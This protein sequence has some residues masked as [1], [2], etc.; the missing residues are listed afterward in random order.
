VTSG[1]RSDWRWVPLAFLVT[2]LLAAWDTR[3]DYSKAEDGARERISALTRVVEARTNQT[4]QNVD[5]MLRDAGDQLP[6]GAN[7]GDAAFHR[8]LEAR[9]HI[10]AEALTITIVSPEGIIVN[11]SSAQLVGRNVGNRSYLGHFRAHPEDDSLF[12]GE[13]V[14]A[15]LNR[16]VVFAA[17]AIRD[18][19]GG[20]RAIAVSALLPEAFSSLLDA[21]V[22]SEPSGA[23]SL[24]NRDQIILARYPDEG[25]LAV[26]QSLAKAP[27][28]IAHLAG[29]GTPSY[30]EGVGGIDGVRRLIGVRTIQPYGITVGVSIAK[31]DVMNPVY[32]G[33]AGNL[34]L[35][36]AV[37]GGAFL[38][39]RNAR[40]RDR[41]RAEAER[42]LVRARDH[43][44]KILDDF[45]A[46]IRLTDDL[47]QCEYVNH[48]WA[49]FTGA[50]AMAE[51]GQG[52]IA[53]VHPEDMERVTGR[54]ATQD[55]WEYRLRRH[56]GE[57]R[58]LHE[59]CRPF[60]NLDGRR[61]GTLSACLDVTE[62]RR[63]QQQ[64]QRS[65]ADL[66]QFA[67]VASHDL[68]EPLRMVSNFMALLERRYGSQLGDE[69]REFLAF[70]KDGAVRMDRLVLDLLDFSRVG[71]ISDPPRPN[72]VG[73]LV[74]RAVHMLQAVI[75]QSGAE[76]KVSSDLPVVVC[77]G[78]EITR[79][80]QNLI[81]NAVKFCPADRRPVVTISSRPEGTTWQFTVSDNGIGI[82]P[83]YF[84]R[85]FLIFQ[86]LHTREHYEGTGIGL[87]VCKKIIERHGGSSFHFTLPSPAP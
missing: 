63:F 43:Y 84:D 45:P 37:T 14:E 44:R 86:R 54:S 8:Y 56:D 24:S 52:W 3:Q 25:G 41:S 60:V 77:A 35:V 10:S 87:A 2:A 75:A 65:N 7:L 36:L 62:A 30:L 64:L 47:G 12:I 58:W 79:V 85:I 59:V 1:E 48:S 66:E 26:G 51:L 73:D 19:H 22:P 11:S 6:Q 70:A 78:D 80:F 29:G 46:L 83:D 23:I 17:R 53:H 55:E 61:A 28:M 40:I 33:A 34:A 68:R 9:S 76:I 15:L 21:A 42:Q 31:S 81:G 20:L 4:F 16:K 71:R 67:Y 18:P 50:D 32:R 49:D 39:G 27:L 38:L 5:Q 69:G 82:E 72:P 57:Y 13:P 74:A